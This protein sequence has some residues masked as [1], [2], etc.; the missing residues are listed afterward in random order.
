MFF[1]EYL[2]LNLLGPEDPEVALQNLLIELG[3]ETAPS[4]NNPSGQVVLS[5]GNSLK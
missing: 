1:G 4:I 2:A 5:G 3:I